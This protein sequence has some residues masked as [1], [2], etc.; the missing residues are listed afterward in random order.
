M[1]NAK[2]QIF[3]SSI[4]LSDIFCRNQPNFDNLPPEN[5]RWADLRGAI[6][7]GV[8]SYLV[9]LRDAKLNPDQ[10]KYVNTVW[11][12]PDESGL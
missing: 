10:L 3:W 5:L 9:D 6:L 12:D 8:D 4:F 7:S 2:G 11:C 1:S